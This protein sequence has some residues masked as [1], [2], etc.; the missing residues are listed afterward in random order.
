MLLYGKKLKNV[1][2]TEKIDLTTYTLLY[3]IFVYLNWISI[4]R[5]QKNIVNNNIV[6]KQLI[7]SSFRSKEITFDSSWAAN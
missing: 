3:V 4:T 2:M 6:V 7:N 1:N 5:S